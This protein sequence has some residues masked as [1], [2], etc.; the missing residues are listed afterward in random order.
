MAYPTR[1]LLGAPAALTA[2]VAIAVTSNAATARVPCLDCVF[3]S[4]SPAP[5]L[6]GVG[7]RHGQAS[8][9]NSLPFYTLAYRGAM[10]L[11]TYKTPFADPGDSCSPERRVLVKPHRVSRW[12]LIR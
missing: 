4:S 12:E 6:I 7:G 3:I 1:M 8:L 11:S 9:L 10:K 2:E 5:H